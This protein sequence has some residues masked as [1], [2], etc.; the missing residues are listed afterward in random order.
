[1]YIRCILC[2]G[3]FGNSEAGIPLDIIQIA[4]EHFSLNNMEIQLPFMLS[5]FW[6]FVT[7]PI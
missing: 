3:S 2:G 7:S 1:M 4:S 5:D 6:S